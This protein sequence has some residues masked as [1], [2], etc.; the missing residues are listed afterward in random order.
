M[1]EL[2]CA[3][4]MLTSKLFSNLHTI[5]FWMNELICFLLTGWLQWTP[6]C[7]FLSSTNVDNSHPL[8]E[9][10]QYVCPSEEQ[11]TEEVL[12]L[13]DTSQVK[14]NGRKCRTKNF[15]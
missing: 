14:A 10:T 2:C 4:F 9:D 1:N 7:N 5:A 13:Q 12:I 11:E 3:F 15:F 8:W 6:F